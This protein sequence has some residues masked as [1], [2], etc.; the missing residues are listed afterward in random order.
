M[1][2]INEAIFHLQSQPTIEYFTEFMD[3]AGSQIEEDLNLKFIAAKAKVVLGSTDSSTWNFLANFFESK[4]QIYPEICCTE[5]LLFIEHEIKIVNKYTKLLTVYNNAKEKEFALIRENFIENYPNTT[6]SVIMPTYN[7]HQYIGRAI[8]SVL[9]QTF[10]DFELIIINDGGSRE[11]E[12]IINSFKSEKVRYLYIEHGG[13]SYALNQGILASRS[14]YIAYLDDDDR[15]YPNHLEVLLKGIESSSYPFV[16]S[17]SYRL[18]KNY[19][20]GKWTNNSKHIFSNDYDPARFTESNY[21]PIL[22]IMHKREC[23][24]RIGF[25]EPDFPNVM[26]WD[27]WYKASRL[28]DFKHIKKVTCEFEYRQEPDSLSGRQLDHIFYTILLRKHHQYQAINIKDDLS[29]K[30]LSGSIKYDKVEKEVKR[31]INNR[32]LLVEWLLPFI[33]KEYKLS[34]AYTLLDQIIMSN[35]KTIFFPIIKRVFLNISIF[36]KFFLLLFT[37]INLIKKLINKLFKKIMKIYNLE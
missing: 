5:A 19:K 33:F 21:I 9:N 36:A 14:K 25:F 4:K 35:S 28:F 37:A 15:Y 32:T 34:Y 18:V 22:N 8:K 7:R 17:D 31:Y 26:D 10:K 30:Y 20:N 23:H 24:E 2:K 27:L 13:L 1:K 16:Y 29:K 6:V 12:K 3:I 11:C